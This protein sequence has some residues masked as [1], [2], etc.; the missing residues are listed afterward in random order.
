MTAG[1]TE[2]LEEQGAPSEAGTKALHLLMPNARRKAALL[3]DNSI[4]K[5]GMSRYE[6]C[7]RSLLLFR[8]A[9]KKL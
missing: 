9:N 5:V 8:Q 1:S 6:Y 3:A 4:V 7:G 2:R